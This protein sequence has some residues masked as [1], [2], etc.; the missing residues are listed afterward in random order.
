MPSVAGRRR[1]LTCRKHPRRVCGGRRRGCG[2][3]RDGQLGRWPRWGTE[4]GQARAQGRVGTCLQH[5]WRRDRG[6]RRRERRRG[7]DR[8]DGLQSR[9]HGRWRAG[10][11]SDG[12]A[13]RHGRIE[14]RQACSQGPGRCGIIGSGIGVHRRCDTFRR[15]CSGGCRRSS[16]RRALSHLG[17]WRCGFGLG[18]RPPSGGSPLVGAIRRCLRLTRSRSSWRRKRRC[19]ARSRHASAW[20]ELRRHAQSHHLSALLSRA[21]SADVSQRCPPIRCTSP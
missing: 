15:C 19:M 11:R 16:R 9:V 12:G 7:R 5:R 17:G 1:A 4:R 6:G 18:H 13:G 8:R 10:V 2:C 3:W 21:I 14:D 20:I